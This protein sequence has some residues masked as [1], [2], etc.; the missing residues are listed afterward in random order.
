MERTVFEGLRAQI[1]EVPVIRRVGRLAEIGRG[2]FGSPGWAEPPLATGWRSTM[3][4]DLR[5]GGEIL[6]L[7][8][9][10]ATV[11]PDGGAEGLS[12]G[13]AVEL[14][15][16]SGIAPDD[17][18]IG[19]IVDPFGKPL[20]GRPLRRGAVM[21]PLRAEAPAATTRRRLGAR[22]ETGL[23]VF[24]TMLPL[25]RGQRIGL[26]AGSG[27]GKSMLLSK[28]ARGSRPTWS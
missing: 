26:F 11:L 25:V 17:S 20:D 2:T 23:A 8:R 19:R 10:G 22:M 9:E 7:S 12:I 6:R 14:I 18:W 28:F 21:R 27:V 13:D 4:Q 1:A 3:A 5:I 24:N 15:G 16:S